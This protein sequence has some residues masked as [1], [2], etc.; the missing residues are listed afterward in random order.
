MAIEIEESSID[1][2]ESKLMD[3][4]DG[5]NITAIIFYLKKLTK[6]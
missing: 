5:G 4:V 3:C 2:V 1:Y 6:W